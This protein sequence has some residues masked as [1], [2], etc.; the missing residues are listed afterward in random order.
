MLGGPQSGR[1]GSV[2]QRTELTI[3]SAVGGIGPAAPRASTATLP[4]PAGSNPIEPVF[5]ELFARR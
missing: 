3:V 4:L 1:E 5:G 2:H